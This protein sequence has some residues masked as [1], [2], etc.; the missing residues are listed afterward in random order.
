MKITLMVLLLG[1]SISTPALAGE[2]VAYDTAWG[3][4]CYPSQDSYA[5]KLKNRTGHPVDFKVCLERKS[6]QWAC[7]VSSNVYP[8]EVE[9]SSW[10]YYVCHGTGQAKLWWRDAG[11]Y[12]TRF[13]RP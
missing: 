9:P 12:G 11:D 6:G 3:R 4:S 5:I 8:G 10:G 13:P 7:Y 1:I 2:V